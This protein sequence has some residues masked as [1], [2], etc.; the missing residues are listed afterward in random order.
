[1]KKSK[2]N[3]D[4]ELDKNK[5]MI[6]NTFS[7][8]YFVYA[9]N[10]KNKVYD[11]IENIN[12]NVYTLEEIEIIKNL[13]QSRIL[14]ENDRDELKELEYFE[15]TV[16]YQS[17]T[18]S[19][20]I[21]VTEGC[22]FRCTYC[23]QDHNNLTLDDTSESKIINLINNV[24][25]KVKK[26]KL[27]WFGGEPLL[28]FERIERMTNQIISICEKN[29]CKFEAGMTT[30]GYLLSLD[31]VK[32]MKKMNFT[33]VQITLDGDRDTHDSRRFTCN[34]EKTYD[35][36]LKNLIV[37]LS[38]SLSVILRINIDKNNLE[39]ASSIL[40]IIP[41]KYRKNIIISIA[42]LYQQKE[43]CSVYE[44]YK[45]AIELGYQCSTRYNTYMACQVCQK[46][47]VVIG[48]DGNIIVCA[49][50][51]NDNKYLGYIDTNGNIQINDIS[52]YF[53]LKTVSAIHNPQC[54][55]CIELPLCIGSC[56]YKRAQDNSKCIGKRNDGFSIQERAK[57]D[58]LLDKRKEVR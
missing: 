34:G 9:L 55:N 7:R 46:N 11:L 40:P 41:I 54:V 2:Y 36:I 17:D 50:A 48:A 21:I 37:A 47:G 29:C 10:E 33:F 45:Y 31:K 19:I 1:M 8:K 49:N 16:K 24:S 39:K 20:M 25:K 30:N 13:I 28:Q 3:V 38:E 57:L 18:F 5:G 44:V 15:N 14:I 53:K 35:V 26:I 23:I 43:K 58:Y 6:Y 27:S 56:K 32:I 52:Q 22:N 4:I 51:S 12:K 42:N